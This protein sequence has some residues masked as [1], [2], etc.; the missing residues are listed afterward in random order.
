MSR[1]SVSIVVSA[2]NEEGNVE[3]LY[4][5]LKKVLKEVKLE[6]AEIIYVDDGTSDKSSA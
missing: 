5:E 1:N 6:K 4:K 3:P 2:Y